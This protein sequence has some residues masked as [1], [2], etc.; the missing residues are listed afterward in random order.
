MGAPDRLAHLVRKAVPDDLLIEA[1]E[2]AAW[3]GLRLLDVRDM[4]EHLAQPVAGAI[5]VPVA[6][7]TWAASTL[8][9]GLENT[10]FWHDQLLSLG[11]ED[12]EAVAV[13]DDGRLNE[14]ARV[15]FILQWFGLRAYL[16]N[17]GSDAL[18]GRDMPQP[19]GFA[20]GGLTLAPGT[21][22]VPLFDRATLRARLGEGLAVLDARTPA[23]YVGLDV[24]DNPRGGHLP[25]ARN[26]PHAA[27]MDG[28]RLRP[29]AELRRIFNVAGFAPDAPMVAH[30]DRGGRSALTAIAA[31]RAGFTDVAVYFLSFADWS[32]DASYPVTR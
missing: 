6:D 3:P 9:T 19:A 12:G 2:V 30:C 24:R 23:E 13:F 22:P 14:A 16:V 32:A 28:N 5:H 15:W 7:W 31:L 1:P 29:A 10:A 11:I 18:R 26:L 21:G 4:A 25:G 27:L 8:G 17:G 20:E